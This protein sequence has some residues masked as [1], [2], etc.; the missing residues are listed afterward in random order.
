MINV[1]RSLYRNS[2]ILLVEDV[3]WKLDEYWKKIF[4][5]SVVLD[6]FSHKTWVMITHNLELLEKADKVVYMN[7]KVIKGVATYKSSKKKSYF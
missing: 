3:V 1:A 4:L 7:K 6:E 5:E 2:S